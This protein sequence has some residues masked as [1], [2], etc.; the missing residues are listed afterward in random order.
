MDVTRDATPGSAASPC[1]ALRGRA[2]SLS[3]NPFLAD[4]CLDHVEDALIL[5]EAGPDRGRRAL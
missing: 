4:G 1:R 2:A 3:G 5:I